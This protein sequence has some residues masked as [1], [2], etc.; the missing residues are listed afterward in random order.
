M[1]EFR[2][3]DEVFGVKG[4]AN[5]ELV[6]VR[7]SGVHRAQADG[8]TFEEAAALRD[9]ACIA[10]SCF[11]E[12]DV[13]EERACSCTAR[14]A[15]SAPPRSSSRTHFGADVTAVC[16]TKTSTSSARSARD[17]VIDHLREDFTRNG[18]P[19]T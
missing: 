5:A 8:A 18:R 16:N 17:E 9:G 2:V 11:R 13:R 3:G 7:E 4:G 1:T 19:T 14:Q 6:A 15:R 12:P 10:L